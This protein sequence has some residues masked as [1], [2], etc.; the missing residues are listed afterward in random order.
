MNFLRNGVCA[1]IAHVLQNKLQPTHIV[2]VLGD[3]RFVRPERNVKGVS[4]HAEGKEEEGRQ[5]EGNQGEEEEE[6]ASVDSVNVV[7]FGRSR[8]T[9]GPAVSE[10]KGRGSDAFIPFQDTIDCGTQYDVSYEICLI[11]QW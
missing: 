11:L 2:H 1:K 9:I 3:E 8:L 5:E 4:S 10:G 6:I 7:V